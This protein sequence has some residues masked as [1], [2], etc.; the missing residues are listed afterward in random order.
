MKTV[1][2][3]LTGE[4]KINYLNKIIVFFFFSRTHYYTLGTYL[5]LYKIHVPPKPEFFL[6]WFYWSWLYHLTSFLLY[7]SHLW[8]PAIEQ[9]PEST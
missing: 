7:L 5:H 3:L 4:K 8:T 1:G 2:M 6:N 9:I